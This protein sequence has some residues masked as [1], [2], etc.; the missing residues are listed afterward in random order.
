MENLDIDA[1]VLQKIAMIERVSPEVARDIRD[2][3]DDSIVEYARRMYQLDRS[4]PSASVAFYRGKLAAKL[5]SRAA[6]LGVEV[7]LQ[8]VLDSFAEFPIIQTAPHCQLYLDPMAFWAYVVGW[9]GAFET[10]CQLIPV[11]NTAT[12]TLQSAASSGPAWLSTATGALN[13]TTSPSSRLASTSVCAAG[14]AVA[15]DTAKLAALHG[16]AAPGEQRVI[17]MLERSIAASPR[18]FAHAT[19]R[20]NVNLLRSLSRARI[21]PV[22]FSESLICD[23]MA[24]LL[25]DRDRLVW[26]LL[27]E[28]ARNARLH[29]AF[30]RASTQLYGHFW[31]QATSH[32]WGIRDRKIRRLELCDGWLVE[33]DRG[34]QDGLR[35]RF[36]C[37]S[38]IEGL[39]TELLVP[40]LFWSFALVTLLPRLSAIGGTRQIGYLNG[41]ADVLRRALDL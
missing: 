41:F 7:S 12:V 37:D 5:A 29:A 25:A 16:R 15:F 33:A 4:P 13:I 28:P 27:F 10:G 3:L 39:R 21:S 9:L 38:L 36:E 14:T 8:R 26:G 18:G 35:V 34:D 30:E 11:F 20:T 19:D 1:S 6:E 22:M 40:N 24:D 23:L 31:S 2:G 17:A 32:F